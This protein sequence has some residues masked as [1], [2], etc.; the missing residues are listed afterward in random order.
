MAVLLGVT[1]AI[2]YP[3]G[4][5]LEA[6]GHFRIAMWAFLASLL[7]I[8]AGLWVTSASGSSSPAMAGL[9]GSAAIQGAVFLVASNHLGILSLV[10][11]WSGIR[12][13]LL[14]QF[15]F[16]VVLMGVAAFSTGVVE[17]MGLVAVASTEL[18]LLWATRRRTAFGRVAAARGLPG[19]N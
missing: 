13:V 16:T 5:A 8:G 15:G 12:R 18:I 9:L 2:T 14:V 19:F 1:P 6:L 11:Y 17:L 4:S 7:A 3:L 10:T